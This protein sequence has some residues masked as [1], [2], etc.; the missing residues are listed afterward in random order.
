MTKEHQDITQDFYSGNTKYIVVTV[1]KPDG[2]AKDLQGSEIVYTIYTDKAVVALRKT[3]VDGEIA[4][5]GTDHNIAT[6]T[7]NSYDTFPLS[8]LYR[9][10]MTITDGSGVTETVMRGK[11]E[12]FKSFASRQRKT[13]KHVYLLGG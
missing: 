12:V 13:S 4:V 9:H 2:T 10:E 5:S 6:A 8:G 7:L 11:V 3:S 1:L